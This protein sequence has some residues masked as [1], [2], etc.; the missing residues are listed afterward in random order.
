MQRPVQG[1]VVP[2]YNR[3]SRQKTRSLFREMREGSRTFLPNHQPRI[4]IKMSTDVIRLPQRSEVLEADTWDLSRLF[5]NDDQWES[6]FQEFEGMIAGYQEFQGTLGESAQ[7][8]KECLDFDSDVSRLAERLGNYAFLRSSE[9]Q[10]NSDYQRMVGRFQNVATRAGEAASYIRPEIL[11]IDDEQLNTFLADDALEL[12]RL[13]LERL[14]R[15]KPYTLGEKEEQLLAMQGE[16]AGTAS[17][18]FRQ[19]HDSDLKFGEV[20]DEHGQSVELTSS[21]LSQFLISPD[22]NV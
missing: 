16:M 9:D 19:L 21:T 3:S 12:Y 10:A 4:E 11:A 22:R 15:Y 20:T 2:P 17:K 13:S 7:K 8:L 1:A 6:S 14:T 5:E 18:V